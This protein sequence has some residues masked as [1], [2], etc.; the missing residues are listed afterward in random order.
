MIVYVRS[1]FKIKNEQIRYVKIVSIKKS[2]FLF[3][4]DS[5]R[6]K[7]EQK[8][9]RTQEDVIDALYT[10]TSSNYKDH[11]SKYGEILTLCAYVTNV[12]ITF[13]TYLFHKL[14]E[15]EANL[16]QHKNEQGSVSTNCGLLMELLK[17]DLLFQPSYS[18][19]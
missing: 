16:E 8:V 15:L 14:K 13:K 9:Q 12:S 3:F 17:G 2:I 18:I 1:K 7:D 5:G 19:V 10:Y 6:L 11:T 4:K